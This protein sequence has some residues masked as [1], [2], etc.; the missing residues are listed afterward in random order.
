[1]DRE[2]LEVDSES[3]LGLDYKIIPGYTYYVQVTKADGSPME[4]TLGYEGVRTFVDM[5]RYAGIPEE[6]IIR[7]ISVLGE[8]R[9]I[10]L[11]R[12]MV[13]DEANC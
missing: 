6:E 11:T 4:T 12:M 2:L 7:C 1:M 9:W 13:R 8:E 10:P 5:A 3:L